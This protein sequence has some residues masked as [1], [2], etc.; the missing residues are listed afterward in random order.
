MYLK[1]SYIDSEIMCNSRNCNHGFFVSVNTI[2]LA[3]RKQIL[4]VLSFIIILSTGITL[5][6]RILYMTLQCDMPFFFI[7]KRDYY[8]NI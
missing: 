3:D 1:N 8:S 7:P 5:F 4:L 2:L 6:Q